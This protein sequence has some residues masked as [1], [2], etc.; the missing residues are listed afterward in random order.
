[1]SNQL[2]PIGTQHL[3]AIV[4][5]IVK[6]TLAGSRPGLAGSADGHNEGVAW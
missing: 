5:L 1:M 3:G 4:P 2:Y 6:R